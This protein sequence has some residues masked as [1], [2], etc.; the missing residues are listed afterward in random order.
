LRAVYSGT[1]LITQRRPDAVTSSGTMPGLIA[2]M[3]HA[4]AVEDGDTVLQ[5]GTGTGYTAAL[6]CERLGSG[7]VVSIDVDPQ[8]TEPA[9]C[10]MRACGYSPSVVTADAMNGYPTRAPYDRVVATFALPHIPTAWLHQ[11]SDGGVILAPIRS[12]F[13]RL[14]VHDGVV[15]G[16]FLASGAYFMRYRATVDGPVSPARPVRAVE[17]PVW[18]RRVPRLPSSV[19]WDNHFKFIVDLFLPELDIG[20]STGGLHERRWSL[21]PRHGR[22][23][24]PR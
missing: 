11:T 1:T 20:H 2:L 21:S 5:V 19:V 15:D 13:A 22:S 9:Q 3:L 17:E 24:A 16:R 6:L 4:L 23:P 10:R 18:P 14:T 12:A 7:R 8:L